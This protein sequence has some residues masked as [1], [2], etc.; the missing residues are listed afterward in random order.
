MRFR[1]EQHRYTYTPHWHMAVN[2]ATT[3]AQC[4]THFLDTRHL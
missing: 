1:R 3:G 2:G 4:G